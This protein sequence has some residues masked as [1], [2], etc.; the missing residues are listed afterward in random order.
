MSE[1]YRCSHETTLHVSYF[2]INVCCAILFAEENENNLEAIT[3]EIL[4]TV[5]CWPLI[6]TPNTLWGHYRETRAVL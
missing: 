5:K 2:L 6:S 1:E 4:H 3:E